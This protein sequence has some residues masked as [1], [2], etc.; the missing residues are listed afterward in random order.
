MKS[1]AVPVTIWEHFCEAV[2]TCDTIIFAAGT[3]PHRAARKSGWILVAGGFL[4]L[5]EQ[6]AAIGIETSLNFH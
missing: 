3:P 5:D 4:V 1:N 6:P 2:C